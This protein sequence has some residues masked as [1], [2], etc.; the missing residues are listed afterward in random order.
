MESQAA[1]M[2]S[3]RDDD[4]RNDNAVEGSVA[5]LQGLNDQLLEA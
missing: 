3:L 2:E 5:E 4:G 1:A